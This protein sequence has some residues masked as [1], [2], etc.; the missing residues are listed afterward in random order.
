ML[1]P[2]SDDIAPLGPIPLFPPFTYGRGVTTPKYA[3]RG[4][5]L[6]VIQ[7]QPANTRVAPPDRHQAA[8]R[9]VAA[10]PLAP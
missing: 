5:Q 9:D 8:H 7:A 6:S 1:C 4:L 10:R 2:F 3:P